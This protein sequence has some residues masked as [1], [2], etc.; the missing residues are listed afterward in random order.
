MEIMRNIL[1]TV[2]AAVLAFYSSALVAAPKSIENPD[3]FSTDIVQMI[4]RSGS[5]NAAKTL[6]ETMGQITQTDFL[7]NALK[8]FD[9]K[10]IDFSSKVVDNE[11]GKALRQIIHYSYVENLGFVYFRFNFKMT[12]KGWILANFTFKT[13]TN[14]LFP[15]DFADR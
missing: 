7:H 6:A 10:T 3:K 5:H 15:K 9:G 2:F 1:T 4:S 13:E 12:S 11:I 14:E 8:V